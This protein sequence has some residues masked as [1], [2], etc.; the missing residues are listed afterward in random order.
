MIEGPPDIM[1]GIL[2]PS[3]RAR[4]VGRKQEIYGPL[5]V[6][7]HRIVDPERRTVTVLALRGSVYES[8][9]QPGGVARSEALPDL[10]VDVAALFAAA[11]R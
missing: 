1:V 4:D 2:S 10:A 5:G 7:E 6:P 8:L 3:T 9:T 11:R